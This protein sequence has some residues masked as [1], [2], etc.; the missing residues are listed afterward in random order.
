MKEQLGLDDLPF[1]T[2]STPGMSFR[3]AVLM[4]AREK[5]ESLVKAI[6]NWA[7]E[8]RALRETC[9][10]CN[11]YLSSNSL[12]S[13]S[14]GSILHQKL[15]NLSSPSVEVPKRREYIVSSEW[16]P[17]EHEVAGIPL[18]TFRE[19][20]IERA[21]CKCPTDNGPD[22]GMR[23]GVVG[24]RCV[25]CMLPSRVAVAQQ[26]EADLKRENT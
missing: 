25:R 9:E 24:G 12:N 16:E 14:S 5:P 6:K 21:M 20:T 3:E 7:Q 1:D 4:M 17:K 23:P 26:M 2:G 19:P 8:M 10:E 11:K 13:I 18:A 22:E 15:R